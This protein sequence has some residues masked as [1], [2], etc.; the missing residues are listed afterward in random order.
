MIYTVTLNPAIDK[1]VAV[2]NF[3][4]DEVNRIH[5]VKKDP[6]GKGI[7]VS[8]MVHKLGGDSVALMVAGGHN[9]QSL[10][11][12]V[13][14]LGLTTHVVATRE[15]TRINTK[16]VDGV[17]STFTDIN[18]PGPV[19][20]ASVLAQV[21]DYLEGHLKEGDFLVMAGSL[22]R[23]VPRD[24]YGR[25][26]NLAH[27]KGARAILDASGEALIHGAENMP[28]MVK[29]NVAELE[30]YFGKSLHNEAAMIEC[31]KA[32]IA[33]GIAYV[34]ISQG[35]EGCLVVGDGQVGKIAPLKLKV[36]STVGAGDAMVGAMVLNLERAMKAGALLDFDKFMT[37]AARGVAAS[38]ATIQKPGTLMAE[39][40]E[41][42]ALF[43]EISWQII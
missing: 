20:E 29:P 3:T 4:M 34:V 40:A 18:E 33:K 43:E 26:T 11:A 35:E 41:V 30:G 14:A 10:K 31:G 19:L 42:E 24:I 23:G 38:S 1:T 27:R 13:T 21:T 12:M 37:I 15:E 36:K 32:L 7:N 9:G 6:G 22:P 39:K 8:H 28:F 16:V 25:L 5:A 2:D 17:K